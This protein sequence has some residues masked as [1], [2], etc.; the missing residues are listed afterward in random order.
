MSCII[1]GAKAAFVDLIDTLV[2]ANPSHAFSL[3]ALKKQ[4]K[5]MPLCKSGGKRT[6]S[7]LPR[8]RSKWQE[9]IA[10]ERKG[11]KFDPQAIRELA[12][13]YRAGQCP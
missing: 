9:C 2:E 10:K 13:K 5:T 4:I 7:G 3:S 1:G 6:K 12:K 11:K 8:K